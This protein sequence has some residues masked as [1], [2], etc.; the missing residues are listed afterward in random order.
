MMNQL[1]RVKEKV[2]IIVSDKKWLNEVTCCKV[3]RKYS[4]NVSS[5]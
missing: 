4:E 5:A 2:M 3:L 1:Y